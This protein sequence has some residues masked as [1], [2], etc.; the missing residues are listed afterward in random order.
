MMLILR[1]LAGLHRSDPAHPDDKIT[2]KHLVR[3]DD[4]QLK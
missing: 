4:Q 2:M 3:P 1:L